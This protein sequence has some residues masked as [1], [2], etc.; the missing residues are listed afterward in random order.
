MLVELA[1][2]TCQGLNHHHVTERMKDREEI[3]AP[4]SGGRVAEGETGPGSL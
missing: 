1:A 2:T 4:G 3:Y